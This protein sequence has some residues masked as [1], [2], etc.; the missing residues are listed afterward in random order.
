MLHACHTIVHYSAQPEFMHRHNLLPIGE[1]L[2]NKRRKK[3]IKFKTLSRG[4]YLL[5]LICGA[6]QLTLKVGLVGILNPTAVGLLYPAPQCPAYGTFIFCIEAVLPRKGSGDGGGP[7]YK[8]QLSILSS[9]SQHSA[10]IF[11][12]TSN[13]ISAGEFTRIC[14]N[15]SVS[16]LLE[17]NELA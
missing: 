17:I 16:G 6:C 13:S 2:L 4:L 9:L 14:K 15:L 5:T 10:K 11:E 12:S 3:G 1:A 8:I 7:Y